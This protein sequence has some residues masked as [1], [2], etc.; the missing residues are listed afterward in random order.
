MGCVLRFREFCVAI[1][2][3][4]DGSP[5]RMPSPSFVGLTEMTQVRKVRVAIRADGA[6]YEGYVHLVEE[7]TRVQDVLND[8]RPF[9]NLTE[10]VLHDRSFPWVALNKGAITHLMVLEGVPAEGTARSSEAGVAPDASA[11]LSPAARAAARQP[12]VPPAGP[13]TLPAPPPRPAGDPPTQPFPK[14]SIG[15]RSG[16]LEDDLLLDEDD[17]DD[18]DPDD[19]ERDVG[20]L[21]TGSSR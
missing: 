18:I 2:L 6:D 19:L 8:P 9:L 10:V 13:S 11:G 1:D 16:T 15:P 3:P 7:G 12:T 4:A 21:I 14:E 20:A 5:D 17:G